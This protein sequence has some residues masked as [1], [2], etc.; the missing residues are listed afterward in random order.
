VFCWITA[1]VRQPNDIKES[2]LFWDDRKYLYK[3]VI[4]NAVTCVLPQSQSNKTCKLE[5]FSALF[6]GFYCKNHV[7]LL[8]KMHFCGVHGTG[9]NGFRSY[10]TDRKQIVEMKSSKKQQKIRIKHASLQY[11]QTAPHFWIRN[12]TLQWQSWA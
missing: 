7:I 12:V 5:K 11:V 8:G 4:N 10:L 2:I 6:Q 9:T 1:N 3:Y